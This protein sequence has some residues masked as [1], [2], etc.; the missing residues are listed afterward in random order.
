MRVRQLVNDLK[1]PGLW[2]LF[3]P[4]LFAVGVAAV[5][6][7]C[8]SNVIAALRLILA[9]LLHLAATAFFALTMG[10]GGFGMVNKRTL[11]RANLTY[12]LVGLGLIG[13]LAY[14]RAVAPA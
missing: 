12:L 6:L 2:L 3:G 14:W 1:Q 9:V 7:L 4:A 13:G 11:K 5:S 8:R 10:F